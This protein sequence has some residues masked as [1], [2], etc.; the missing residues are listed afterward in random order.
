[1]SIWGEKM[2]NIAGYVGEKEAAPIL[3]EMLKREEIFDGGYSTG[4]ITIHNGKFYCKR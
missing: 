4:I 2:C 1:M 3:V